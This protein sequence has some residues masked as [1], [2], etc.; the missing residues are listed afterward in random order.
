MIKLI[1]NYILYIRN[2]KILFN[3][4]G[5]RNEENIFTDKRKPDRK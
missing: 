4:G 5:I 3:N 1:Y 2:N